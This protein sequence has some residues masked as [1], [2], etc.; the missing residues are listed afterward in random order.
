MRILFLTRRYP[1]STGGLQ[2]AAYE[3]HKALAANRDNQVELIKWGGSN[4]LLPF[5][6]VWMLLKALKSGFVKRPDVIY[7]QDGMMAPMGSILKLFLRRPTVITIHGKEATYGNPLYKIMVPPFVPRQDVLVTISEDTKQTVLRAF[8]GAK[9]I[10]IYHGV[11]DD[12]RTPGSRSDHRAKLAHMTGIPLERLK[13]AKILHTNGRL[14]RR[15]GVL[16][17]VDNVLPRLVADDPNILYLVS[18]DGKDRELIR[19][20]IAERGVGENVELLGKVP[21]ALLNQ[22]Y[23]TADIFV[24]PNIPVKSDMEGFGLVAEEAASCGAMVVAS[25][26]EGIADAIVDGKNGMLIKPGDADAYVKTIQRELKHRSISPDAVRRYTLDHYSW[27]E[28]ARQYEAVMQQLVK[29]Y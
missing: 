11:G 12:F 7:L 23:N 22:L 21:Q 26:L 27:S 2:N 25:N 24:M 9:P 5:V 29:K 16:W 17:F 10:I 20:A 19:A 13:K 14:V 1:P 3:F 28:S 4:H 6:Y 18:G 15:K 8:P